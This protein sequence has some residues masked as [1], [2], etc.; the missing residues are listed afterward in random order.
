MRY[1]KKIGLLASMAVLYFGIMAVSTSAQVRVGVHFGLGYYRPTIVRRYYGDPFWNYGYNPYRS[2]RAERYY[3][4]ESV[5]SA[6]KRLQKDEYKFNSDGYLTPK[7]QEKLAE[8][9]RKLDNARD[10]LRRDW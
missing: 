2:E 3:D 1:V 4:R 10:R 9:R 7:E 8:D 5:E 6:Q